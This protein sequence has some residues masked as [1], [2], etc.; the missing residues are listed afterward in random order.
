MRQFPLS[1]QETAAPHL[2]AMTQDFEKHFRN[3]RFGGENLAKDL[4]SWVTKALPEAFHATFDPII[5]SMQKLAPVVAKFDELISQLEQRQAEI[6]SG[7][8][9]ARQSIE[10]TTLAPSARFARRMDEMWTTL[11]AFRAGTP[12]EQMTLAPQLTAQTQD[13]FAQR[14]QQFQQEQALF[15][16]RQGLALGAIGGARQGIEQALFTPEQ[17]QAT[18]EGTLQTMLDQVSNA[19]EVRLD[20][21][22]G[23]GWLTQQVFDQ[24]LAQQNQ[25]IQ[26]FQQQQPQVLSTIQGVRQSIIE[27]A[28]LTP[29]QLGATREQTLQTL[30]GQFRAGTTA[31]QMELAPQIAGSP[32]KCLINSL[33]QHQQAIQ[34]FQQQQQ[35]VLSTIEGARQ[36]IEGAMLTPEQLGATRSRPCRPSSVNFGLAQRRCR[37]S[38]RPRLRA[39]RKRCS[40]PSSNSNSK[41]SRR[42][43]NNK[44]RSWRRLKARGRVSAVQPADS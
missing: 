27:G 31:V 20:W 7:I 18:R 5:E 22:P 6:L 44:P 30:L 33:P 10:E 14:L 15:Q 43:N 36:S 2:Q 8:A 39:S 28:L 16:Q 29:A 9:T 34:A 25:A 37:W 26:A 13:V 1:L 38:W 35:Q 12:A 41:R 42:F 21:C 40:M 32:R 3:V 11:G 23:D 24:F 4:E 17:L 19:A